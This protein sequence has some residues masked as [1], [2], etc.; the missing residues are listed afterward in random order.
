MAPEEMG[1]NA[2]G[3]AKKFGDAIEKGDVGGHCAPSR[4]RIPRPIPRPR[5][6]RPKSA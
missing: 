1:E 5:R 4:A 6:R 2:R 3:N